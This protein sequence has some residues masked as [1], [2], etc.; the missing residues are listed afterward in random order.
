M[1]KFTKLLEHYQFD[2][3][4]FLS[5]ENIHVVRKAFTLLK[6]KIMSDITNFSYSSFP[7][8]EYLLSILL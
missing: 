2:H 5:I 4:E 1:F 6:Y 3:L 7:L 8:L